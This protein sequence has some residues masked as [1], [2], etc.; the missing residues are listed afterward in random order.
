MTLVGVFLLKEAG[1][2]VVLLPS[3]VSLALYCSTMTGFSWIMVFLNHGKGV[4]AVSFSALGATC[5]LSED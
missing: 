2:W 3:L 5:L 1:Q 4:S